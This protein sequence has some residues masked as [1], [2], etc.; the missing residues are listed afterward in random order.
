MVLDLFICHVYESTHNY[1]YISSDHVNMDTY[2]VL[3][4]YIAECCQ[5]NEA[6]L[7]PNTGGGEERERKSQD[8]GKGSNSAAP[9]DENCGTGN[10]HS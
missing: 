9:R 5:L 3:C 4:I 2:I 8:R 7:I 1:V 6:V 10:L